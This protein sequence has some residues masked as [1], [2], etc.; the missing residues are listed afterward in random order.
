MDM[1][2]LSVICSGLGFLEEDE[3]AN[4]IG[5]TKG[6]YSLDNLKDLLRFLRRDDPQ[7]R[8]VFKQVCKW[9]IVSKDLIPIIE[10]CQ[11]DRNLVLNA[12]KVLVF[13]TMP[14]EP[15]STDI[16]Q[17]IEYLWGLKSAFTCSDTI[18]VI[19]SLLE[20]PLENLQQETFTEDDWKLVQLV[21]TL[22]RNV[23]AIQDISLFQKAVGSATQFLSLRDKFL[24]LL[25]D[26]NVM[27]L[28][29]VLAQHVG[30]SH[31]YLRPD[32][33][34]LLETFHY[35]FMGQEPDLIAR[36]YL[37]GPKLEGD[38]A[39]SLKSLR[40]IMEEEEE[41]R[42][43]I[44]LRSLS[45][46]SQFSGI[47]TRLTVDGSKTLFKGNPGSTSSETLSRHHKLHRGPLKRI[48]WD[49]ERLP[50]TKYNLLQLLHNFLNQ[51]LSEAYNVLMQS[52][53]EDI[54]KEHH[55]VQNSDVV[56]FFQVAQFV[57]SFQY[58]KFSISKTNIGT[59]SFEAFP[60]KYVDSTLF[61]G[62]ICGP[63]A[64]SMNE[65]MFLLVTSKWR[66]AFDGLK[67]TNNYKF[68]SAA[69]SLMKIMIRMLDL[70]LKLSSEDSKECQTARTLLYKL[71]Y[72]QTDDGMTQFLLNLIKSFDTHK[73]PKSDLA[74][75]VEMIHVVVRLME[76]LQAH[77]TLR[78][79]RKS[80]KGK[81]KKNAVKDFMD[82]QNADHAEIDCEIGISNCEK[83][84]HLSAKQT[85]NS[86][87]ECSGQEEVTIP[88]HVDGP[89]TSILD[90][91]NPA[92]G[93]SLMDNDKF[94]G[95][96]GLHSGMSDSSGDEQLLMTNEVDFKVSTFVSAFANN[97]V[98][99]NLCWLLKFYK[100]NSTSTN[101]YIICTLRRICDD[102]E[103]SPMLYQLSLVT[104]F[105][106]ILV[107]QKSSPCKEYENIVNFLTSLV[108][109][110]LRK[111]KNQ[112][113]L[114]VEILF[115]KTR[116]ECQYIDTESLLQELGS[117]KNKTRNWAS[118]LGD[119]E[120]GS[121]QDK[122]GIHRSIADALGDDEAD[123]VI[124]H[125]LNNQMEE[126]QYDHTVQEALPMNNRAGRLNESIMPT[127]SEIG[128]TENS[129]KGRDS[130]EHEIQSISKR[131]KRLVLNDELEKKL[132]DLYEKYK[133]NRRCSHLIA[134]AL[135]LDRKVSPVQVFN[136]L[137]RLGIK[138]K[139]RKNMLDTDI[140]FA[141][142][143]NELGNEKAL[144]SGHHPL[145]SNDLDGSLLRT[146]HTRK[147]V[148]AFS[149]DQEMMIKTLFEKFKDHKRCSHMIANALDAHGAFS[150]AQVTRKLKQLGL[151]VPRQ[152]SSQTN[153]HLIDEDPNDILTDGAQQSDD[154]TLL[155]LRK[156]KT[157]Y[158]LKKKD[159]KVTIA[160]V[161]QPG[162][163]SDLRNGI[164]SDV[165]ERDGSQQPGEILEAPETDADRH[166]KHADLHGIA[167]GEVSGNSSGGV[168]PVS[169]VDHSSLQQPYDE[170]ADEL[171]DLGDD[172]A[173]VTSPKSSVR[174][175]LRMVIDMEDDE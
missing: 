90:T 4:R 67:E 152:R 91:S 113:L 28:I 45:R 148:R 96:D 99:Q 49:H 98:I 22:F 20:G 44:R 97:M 84:V 166:L 74:D 55:S 172:V 136:M 79:S 92:D 13:L 153:M 29:L 27:D 56:A 8:E 2:G 119:G 66:S 39:T 123:V 114:F 115:W 34:L 127:S 170:L 11:D 80:R 16:P 135:D 142:G 9:N 173:P 95:N 145:D 175:K 110:M 140:P 50:S 10:H 169:S 73:Q 70:V 151:F 163:E 33:L 122:G 156:R 63:I 86:T 159:E 60:D 165:L 35:I 82:K 88:E 130:V 30:G 121:S 83:S 144:E 155:S 143:P 47:F 23:L 89:G 162:I 94:D 161:Q 38:A 160:S 93:V 109:R 54:E 146:S 69:G 131:K 129:D 25:F 103:L 40:S 168:D 124:S 101:H 52:V 174:R 106:D 139:P 65:S 51:F 32:N 107:E 72:D 6:E 5:Y 57:M 126:D 12:V 100:N 26:E 105:Y 46:Y 19:V 1:E 125:E 171:E 116:K 154:E 36:A 132:K 102:L 53:R 68:L 147:R 41:K 62:D 75:L 112:P 77:G 138:L 137:K 78:V 37:K 167:E 81:K 133:D 61:K 128:A 149:E 141:G 31:G 48:V 108:R 85:E 42:K 87:N 158:V 117:L 134:E 43:L 21:L 104:T 111:M 7:T 14:I 59:N 120:I 24:E 3:D 164:I 17:Q 71:F 58:R 118:G 18:A 64:A 157:R 76:N 150:A 15:P